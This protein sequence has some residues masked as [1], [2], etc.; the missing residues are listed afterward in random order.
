MEKRVKERSY[1]DRSNLESISWGGVHQDLT[2]LLML[3]CAYRQKTRVAALWEALLAADWD[4]CRY[5]HSTIRL[6]SET[7]TKEL[8][9]R[10]K[11]LKGRV[12]PQEG[13]QFQLTWTPGGSQRLSHQPGS[14]HRLVRGPPH[15]Y[16]TG[17][18]GLTSVGKDVPNPQETWGLR[19]GGWGWE[20]GE[21]GEELWVG[22]WG[23]QRLECK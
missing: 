4:I 21:W 13:Q 10:L 3:C 14:I 16:S 11:E 22:G 19:E 9:E 15:L 12:T 6:K 5:F 1:S 18:P 8:E 7:S 23:E 2:P 20:E 17:L